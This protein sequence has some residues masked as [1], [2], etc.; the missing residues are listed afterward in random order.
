ME[1]ITQKKKEREKEGDFIED[2]ITF[3]KKRFRKVKSKTW[4]RGL[5]RVKRDTTI[6]FSTLPRLN[7]FFSLSF[8]SIFDID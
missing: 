7:E 8:V 2:E 4:P 5:E 3:K 1:V 6:A